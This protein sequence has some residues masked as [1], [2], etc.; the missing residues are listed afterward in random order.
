MSSESNNDDQCSYRNL[1]NEEERIKKLDVLT[2]LSVGDTI[3]YNHELYVAGTVGSRCETTIISI[4]NHKDTLAD[5]YILRQNHMVWSKELCG[6]ELKNINMNESVADQEAAA[7]DLN[8]DSDSSSDG[9][10]GYYSDGDYEEFHKNCEIL[11]E[12]SVGDTIMYDHLVLVAGTAGSRRETII[13]SIKDG[14][15]VLADGYILQPNQEI[16]SK[17][18][19]YGQQLTN[20]HLNE[21]EGGDATAA[22]FI[23][24]KGMANDICIFFREYMSGEHNHVHTDDLVQ[25]KDNDKSH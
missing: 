11:M 25:V 5:G 7:T 9:V 8:V 14:K 2:E 3:C 10:G 23:T 22:S 12:L 15:V 1:D 24:E 19:S 18:Y 17:D 4:K 6:R 13:R 20:L 21:G 16:F